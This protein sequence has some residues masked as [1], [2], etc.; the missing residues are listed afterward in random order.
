MK[1]FTI[2][3][4]TIWKASA[5]KRSL[6]PT[7]RSPVTDFL[8]GSLK[9]LSLLCTLCIFL[10]A[11]R[12]IFGIASTRI[13]SLHHLPEQFPHKI[14]QSWKVEATKMES[15]DA[16]RSRTWT[17][18][19]PNYRYEVMT[20]WN[21]DEYVAL[22]FGPLGFNRPDIVSVY[23][24]LTAKIIKQD[25]LRYLIM[26]VEGGVYADIDVEAIRPVTKW[27]PKR[28][29]EAKID[30]VIGIET[31]EPDFKDHPV[32][33]SKAMSFCQ[34]TFMTKPQ[35]PVM[36]R[37]IENIMKWLHKL[38]IKQGKPI[39]E[40][41]LDFNE[42]LSGT[43][44]SAFTVAI[45]EEMS[46]RTHHEVTWD[47]FHDLTEATLVG[48]VL[49]LNAEAFAAGTG[50]SN[51][52]TH[53]G[54]GAMVKHHFHASSWPSQHP[55]F[56]HPVYGE[57]EACNWDMKCVRL[58]TMNTDNFAKLPEG[59]R[60]KMIAL[61]EKDDARKSLP[62]PAMAAPILPAGGLELPAAGLPPAELPAAGGLP[63][64]GA[65][66]ATGSEEEDVAGS[67]SK[68]SESSSGTKDKDTTDKTADSIGDTAVDAKER[69]KDGTSDKG[70]AKEEDEAGVTEGKPRGS[71]ETKAEKADKKKD[72]G[73]IHD[74]LTPG[75]NL[76]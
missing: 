65:G 61:K 70:Q 58:W 28:F 36:M 10:I 3:P 8:F 24:S 25:L 66:A 50:H 62:P 71:A 67:E 51:S 17:T 19:N 60:L 75:L 56:K 55:R 26:Y 47:T 37:L 6:S 53:Q 64:L 27:I 13:P 43:G 45:L 39:S 16:E 41:Y 15:R 48:G 68:D 11:S 7:R 57:V 54:K 14:W 35:L 20:D 31:D 38:S 1:G 69:K 30:L 73:T 42:V 40:L 74:G 12:H 22:H 29:N 63:A 49:V 59:E 23:Q 2:Q 4:P 72:D 33:G 76:G 34:W 5:V 52:G 46:K 18:K 32:L 21:S 9:R 44:P